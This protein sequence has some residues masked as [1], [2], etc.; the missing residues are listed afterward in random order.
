ML[1][2][3]SI[4][5]FQF[6]NYHSRIFEFREKVV[7]I[8]GDNGIGKTN[9]LDAIHYLCFTKSYFSGTDSSN[10]LL[11]TKGF[12]IEGELTENQAPTLVR[13]LLRE[14]GKKEVSCN[15]LPYDRLA[16]HIGRFPAVMIA[17]DDVEL[18]SGGSELRRK[19]IDALIC[20]IDQPYLF[21]LIEYNKVLQQRNSYL[22]Q[23]GSGM[24]RNEVLLE[25]LDEQLVRHGNNIHKKRSEFLPEFLQKTKLLYHLFADHKESVDLRYESNLHDQGMEDLLLA[26][27]EKDHLLQRTS[28]GIHR[29]DLF[30]QMQG[31]AFKSIASQGQRKSMLFALKLAESECLKEKK[32]LAP[33]L[34]LD[35]VFEKLDARR[36]NL[37][38]S[39]VCNELSPQLFLSDTHTKRVKETLG[40]LGID[41][42]SCPLS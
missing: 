10:S 32:G 27:R 28:K 23:T 1:R 41:H 24:P 7:A 40:D 13:V 25:T 15:G 4:E 29:D 36:M 26:T 2:L 20:Q 38:L 18:I 16:N 8:T 39:Y 42:Q 30:I 5:L 37:L 33:L 34:L 6:K 9:L 22:R 35:D 19:L 21:S 17:P 11:G 31:E 3:R 12:R 14:T